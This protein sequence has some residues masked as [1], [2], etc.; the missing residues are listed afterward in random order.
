MLD[1]LKKIYYRQPELHKK[2]YEERFNS[3]FTVHFDFEIKQFNHENSYPAFFYYDADFALLTEKIYKQFESCLS[4][5]YSLPPVVL[6][7][8]ALSSIIEEVKSTNEIEG[9]HSTRR[10]LQEALEEVQASNRFSSIVKKYNML[11]S[12]TP[13]QFYTCRD[14][15]TLY[16]DFAHKE[17]VSLNPANKLDGK[18][19]RKSTVDVQSPTGKILHRGLYP[20]EKIIESMA[21]ALNILNEEK[22]PALI[23]IAV[24]HYF[25]EY[26][27]PF[28]DGN[29]R[30]DRFITSCYIAEHFHYIMALRLSVTI[31]KQR[32]TY[33]KLL[34]ETDSDINMGDLTPFV[35]G[36]SQIISRTF[37]DIEDILKRKHE[38]LEKFKE[39]ITSLNPHDE[40]MQNFY[41]ILLQESLFLGQGVSMEELMKLTGKSRN[42][43]KNKIASLPENHIIIRG[44]KKKF[45]KF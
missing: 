33:Q 1:T 32:S 41:Y 12:Q 27:H 24:F 8:F 4:L 35:H 45:Y 3:P 19:F 25:F 30:T 22:I 43:I 31:K 34:N 5:I 2:I 20:E 11:L 38:Q 29:G 13:V 28:Y 44:N 10:E 16:D 23:R 21:K 42:T 40:F 18:I 17:I 26:I 14:I 39:K 36:F 7:Q 9:V 37:E 6:H 15:R